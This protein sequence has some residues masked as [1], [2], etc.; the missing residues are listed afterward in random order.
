M[1]TITSD[2]ASSLVK[3]ADSIERAPE[4]PEIR[5]SWVDTLR[6]TCP[7]HRDAS[8][9]GFLMRVLDS[10]SLPEPPQRHVDLLRVLSYVVR[11]GPVH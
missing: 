8:S 2:Y 9:R 10:V 7:L 11:K 1:R 6:E 3:L 4:S 5:A